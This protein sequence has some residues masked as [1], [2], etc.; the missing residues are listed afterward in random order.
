M[1]HSEN[2]KRVLINFKSLPTT[3]MN[4]NTGKGMVDW[5]IAK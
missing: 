1:E 5:D 4:I 3:N 2:H